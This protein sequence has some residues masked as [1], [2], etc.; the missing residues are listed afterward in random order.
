MLRALLLLL[1]V[2]RIACS[3]VAIEGVTIGAASQASG[4]DRESNSNLAAIKAL[5]AKDRQQ[6]CCAHADRPGSW[7]VPN[8]IGAG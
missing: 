8:T 7:Q 6:S 4:S 5:V 1:A 2:S 3:Q